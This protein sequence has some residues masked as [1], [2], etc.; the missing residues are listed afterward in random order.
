MRIELHDLSKRFDSGNVILNNMDYS[1]EFQA[2]AIIGPSGG[3][4]STLLR[5]IGGLIEPTSGTLSINGIPLPSGEEELLKYRRRIGFVF[6]QNGLF[7]HM[8]AMENI[9]VPLVQVHG[10][11]KSDAEARASELLDRFG[12]LKDAG[13]RPSALSGG[14]QQ[15]VSIARAIAAKPEFLLLDEPTSALD[16]EYTTEVLDTVN[17]L[18][19]EG[20][21]F[22]IVTHEMGFARHACEKVAFL[23]GGELLEYGESARLF[24]EPKTEELSKFLSKLLEWDV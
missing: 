2:L 3:G 15:R 11:T 17:E 13:K 7:R 22:I 4:K 16:P 10:Y 5:I 20:M 21:D 23:S 1:D 8:T 12:L 24:A 18:K 14:Q 9:T 6:Q 19:E